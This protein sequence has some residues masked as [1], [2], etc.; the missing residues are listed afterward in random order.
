MDLFKALIKSGPLDASSGTDPQHQLPI[1]EH[2]LKLHSHRAK[3]LRDAVYA[4]RVREGFKSEMLRL[5]AELQLERQ[6]QFGKCGKVTGGE[7]VELMLQAF[8]AMRGKHKPSPLAVP[9]SQDV[10]EGIHAIA[11]FCRITPAQV[12]EAL[13]V[14]QINELGLMPQKRG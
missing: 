14:R 12:V 11:R 9:L 3:S 10:C 8:K 6:D 13:V 4:V 2:H 1:E 7:V 5:Q